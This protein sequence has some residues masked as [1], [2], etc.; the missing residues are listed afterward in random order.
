MA[1][2]TMRVAGIGRC[3]QDHRNGS[4]GRSYGRG[5][6]LKTLAESMAKVRFSL[7]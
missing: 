4:V 7:A 3:A 2:S 1:W 6:P 5:V